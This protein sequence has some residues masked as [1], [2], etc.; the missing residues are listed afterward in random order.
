MPLTCFCLLGVKGVHLQP[1][2]DNV[3]R[4]RHRLSEGAGESAAGQARDDAQITLVRQVCSC[5]RAREPA[6]SPTPM[7]QHDAVQIA[8]Q[9][10]FC[11]LGWI[12]GTL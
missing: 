4:I 1:P 3:Q 9:I 6:E 8:G 2:P 10:G 5:Q 7:S 11:R 12:Y